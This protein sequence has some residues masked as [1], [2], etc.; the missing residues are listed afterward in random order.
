MD[1]FAIFGHRQHEDI[2]QTFEPFSFFVI[3]AHTVLGLFIVG[4]DSW[5]PEIR[6]LK[7]VSWEVF[8]FYWLLVLPC[9]MTSCQKA[10]VDCY[11]HAAVLGITMICCCFFNN[12]SARNEHLLSYWDPM[13]P[14][15]G[16][17][18]SCQSLDSHMDTDL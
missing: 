6:I 5:L 1:P 11:L 10:Q 3:F 14:H 15:K 18:Q 2:L 7:F 9:D 12:N 17:G 16:A 8:C 13:D 4:G